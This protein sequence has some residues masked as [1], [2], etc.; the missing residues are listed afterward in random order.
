MAVKKYIVKQYTNWNGRGEKSGTHTVQM[1]SADIEKHIALLDGKIEVYEQSTALSVEAATVTGS[2]DIADKIV[3]KHS[4]IHKPVYISNGNKRPLIFKSPI[5]IVET[6]LKGVKP[7][8]APYENDL[9]FDVSL[10]TGNTNL[11]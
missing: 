5:A 11:L 8:S 9:P 2:S 4:G 10:D 3:L 6:T 1:D 7:F